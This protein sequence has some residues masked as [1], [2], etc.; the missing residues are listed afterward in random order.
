MLSCRISG[1]RRLKPNS[2]TPRIQNCRAMEL[3][4]REQDLDIGSIT[5]SKLGSAE[6]TEQT[7]EWHRQLRACEMAVRL[8]ALRSLSLKSEADKDVM[9][10]TLNN[11]AFKCSEPGHKQL[12]FNL[13][14]MFAIFCQSPTDQ[15]KDSPSAGGLN[16][17]R[18][19]L[20]KGPADGIAVFSRWC[21][22]ELIF[23][24]SSTQAFTKPFRLFRDH[25]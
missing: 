21:C 4:Y 16:Q 19:D 2:K 20:R 7:K 24:T 9:L 14:Q 1:W 12:L 6:N 25:Q 22:A 17:S 23:W 18:V 8:S 10:A 5:R 11:S 13:L 15:T 3:A